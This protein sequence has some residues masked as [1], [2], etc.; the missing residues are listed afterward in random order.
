MP[1]PPSRPA[2]GVVVVVVVAVVAVVV[3]VPG[4]AGDRSGAERWMARWNV[5]TA[6]AV[7]IFPAGERALVE[8]EGDDTLAAVDGAT[9]RVAWTAHPANP[10][11][12]ERHNATDRVMDTAFDPQTR[13]IFVL[14][15]AEAPEGD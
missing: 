1:R 7:A 8:T 14:L 3:A 2:L 10:G 5:A 13:T 6:L 12:S 15:R 4:G 11:R 9:G